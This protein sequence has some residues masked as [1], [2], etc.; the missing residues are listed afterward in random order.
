ML[1]FKLIHLNWFAANKSKTSKRTNKMIDKMSAEKN[2]EACA[3]NSKMSQFRR[4][5]SQVRDFN[6]IFFVLSKNKI[7]SGFISSL[8]PNKNKDYKTSSNVY[9]LLL[10]AHSVCRHNR[11]KYAV[12]RYGTVQRIRFNRYTSTDWHHEWT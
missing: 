4:F 7:L 11:W 1:S 12:I 6:I 8:T 10:I 5:L 9:T 3:I 2:I